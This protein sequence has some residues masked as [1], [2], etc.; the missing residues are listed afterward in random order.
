MKITPDQLKMIAERLAGT[1]HPDEIYLFGSQAS[2]AGRR[3]SD[4][5]ILVVVS[6]EHTDVDALYRQAEAS[7]RGTCLPVE[8]VICTREEFERQKSR[9]SSL[10]HTISRKGR[11]IYAA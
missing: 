3:D 8:I 7:L 10:F 5:D 2:G 1:V 9:V 6:G 11:L 4:I